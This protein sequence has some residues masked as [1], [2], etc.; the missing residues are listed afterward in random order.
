MN[1][2]PL[3]SILPD[4]AQNEGWALYAEEAFFAHGGLGNT[5]DAERSIFGSY[6][7]RI[8]RVVFDVNTETRAW[9]L[10]R[11]ADYKDRAEPGKG[12]I[13]EDLLRALN[14][15]TQLICYYAGEDCRSCRS[16]TT[17]RRSSARRM[18]SAPSTTRSW[19]RARSRSR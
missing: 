11:A 5:T 16:A 6:R 17:T 19:P 8:V 18:T 13:N 3:R 1:A 12:S 4:P 7:Y 9:D 14:W 15:P 10:Q 2:D